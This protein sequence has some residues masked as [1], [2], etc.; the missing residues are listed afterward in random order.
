MRVGCGER[1][2]EILTERSQSEIPRRNKMGILDEI[3]VTTLKCT[4]HWSHC[5]AKQ[6]ESFK[7]TLQKEAVECGVMRDEL[8]KSILPACFGNDS[9]RGVPSQKRGE[10]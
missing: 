1:D 10:Q 6:V 8:S 4:E 3:P 2:A 9:M 5:R 7:P